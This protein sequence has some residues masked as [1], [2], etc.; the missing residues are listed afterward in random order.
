MTD[1]E[2][3]LAS[4]RTTFY[5]EALEDA[6]KMSDELDEM[7]KLKDDE[8]RRRL[9]NT[10]RQRMQTL[11]AA[12]EAADVEPVVRIGL[13]LESLFD[14]LG[15]HL[16]GLTTDFL[17]TV[18]GMAETLQGMLQGLAGQGPALSDKEVQECLDI[19]DKLKSGLLVQALPD[20]ETRLLKP[21]LS[22]LPPLVRPELMARLQDMRIDASSSVM[23]EGLTEFEL[24]LFETF[25]VEAEEHLQALRKLLDDIADEKRP[26]HLPP[27]YHTAN[28]AA[29]TLKGAARAV[30]IYDVEAIA[31]CV[32]HVLAPLKG[33]AIH[34]STGFMNALR[35]AILGLERL[36][37]GRRQSVRERVELTLYM[38][39][40]MSRLDLNRPDE[41]PDLDLQLPQEQPV[42]RNAVAATVS[43][44][45][46]H[47]IEQPEET[48]ELPA[49]FLQELLA[50]FR[51]EAQEQIENINA[52]LL[53]LEKAAPGTDRDALL[54]SIFRG[55]H[56]LKGGARAVGMAEVERICQTLETICAKLRKRQ[57]SLSTHMFDGLL[58]AM[59][60][61]ADL[62]A[63]EASSEVEPMVARLA[64]IEAGFVAAPVPQPDKATPQPP[65]VAPVPAAA[66]PPAEPSPP[67]RTEP[68]PAAAD[69]VRI[70]TAKLDSL[71]A[72]VEEMLAAKL[73]LNQRVRDVRDLS[74]QEEAWRREWAKVTP[75]LQALQAML[76]RRTP[77]PALFELG[78]KVLQF[79]NWNQNSLRGY[80]SRA[81]VLTTSSD[82]DSRVIGG[83]VDNLQE[84]MKRLLMLPFSMILGAF[85][86]AV[87]DMARSLNK[88]V[89][90]EL[91]G[92]E[93]EIDR[94]I[95]EEI[96]DPLLHLVRNSLYHGIEDAP[97]RLGA[98]KPRRGRIGISVAPVYGGKVELV[99]SD[100]GGGIDLAR[101]KR[102]ALAAGLVSV[103]E[104]DRMTEGEVLS[105]IYQS[106][107]TTS[108]QVT[109]I[110]GRGLGLA[111]VR[112]RVKKLGGTINV[113]S[114]RGQGS[115]FIMR[116]PLTLATARGVLVRTANQLFVIP[117]LNVE[118]V[119]RIKPAEIKT[120]DHRET[121]YLQGNPVP[122][123]RLEDLL[124]IAT[125]VKEREYVTVLVLEAGDK[126]LA[127]GV[128]QV[129]GEQE[130]LVKGLGRQ[131]TRVRNV[132]GATILGSGQIAP[133]LHVA[134]LIASAQQRV[135]KSEQRLPVALSVPTVKKKIM[136]VDDSITSRSLIRNIL[137]SVGYTVKTAVDGVE[138]LSQLKGE[139]V[140]LVVSD[141]EMPRMNG[142]ALTEKIRADKSL[143]G[144]PVVLVTT[145]DSRQ[146]RDRGTEV[147]A[148]AY[149]VKGGFNQS[150]LLN[151]IRR[152][153]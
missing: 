139:T 92:T 70:P 25:R 41:Q 50:T 146:D 148:N 16:D 122:I 82:S 77:T 120:V 3:F 13:S 89:E 116:L 136:V 67:P 115:R 98:G 80:F 127:V 73:M 147:G 40:A 134:D 118:R 79:L 142:L 144:I 145:L 10:L 45:L 72:E 87:R 110:A 107:L 88:E 106:D 99:V 29:H 76:A 64:M 121:V 37:S 7:G 132:S 9:C 68:R 153:I 57:L 100:D 74:T 62:M 141:I 2:R 65:S 60:L 108:D 81:R 151:T 34:L 61:T 27:L 137:E 49:E 150:N 83:M 12:A 123:A 109:D 149:I 28:R 86:R 21:D 19:L 39:R 11:V 58:A 125:E 15:R 128:D 135:R 84:D 102:A 129:L 66:A 133:I 22:S 48:Q 91:S 52:E 32:E 46:R 55:L 5:G 44:E 14:T 51:A 126:R 90:L 47:L 42:V 8:R 1:R 93:V 23:G 140:D 71:F 38:V 105:L 114:Q 35:T 143:A 103:N 104:V 78:D 26:E 111:I 36:L 131:L 30:E 17:F 152:L 63:G 124:E 53:A 4:L 56:T 101:V 95:L 6:Q 20:I 119:L 69:T 97:S 117:T 138:A 24:E 54:D 75:D 94:R 33:V 85:P 59:G 113:E 130:V 112:D 96:K 18:G 43:D 31:E